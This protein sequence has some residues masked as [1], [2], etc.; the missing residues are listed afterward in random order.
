MIPGHGPYCD[1]C[2]P[3]VHYALTCPSCKWEWDEPPTPGQFHC[4]NCK[5]QIEVTD[6]DD[7][8]WRRDVLGIPP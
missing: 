5:T 8:N 4:P 7:E 6:D 2:V 3:D 1:L